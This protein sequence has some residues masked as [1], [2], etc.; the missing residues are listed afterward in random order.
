M[1][2]TLIF[3]AGAKV[4]NVK[5]EDGAGLAVAKTQARAFGASVKLV[6]PRLPDDIHL[7]SDAC[8]PEEADDLQRPI[9]GAKKGRQLLVEGG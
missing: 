3:N 8:I 1:Q 5:W 6:K 2:G 4:F 9:E 7:I